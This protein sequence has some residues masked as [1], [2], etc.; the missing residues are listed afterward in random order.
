MQGTWHFVHDLISFADFCGVQWV[1]HTFL[2]LLTKVWN[3]PNH[4]PF[5]KQEAN[6]F[7]ATSRG[8]ID[9]AVNVAVAKEGMLARKKV[10]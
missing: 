10:P 9:T 5:M 3:T 2:I 1:L 4:H 7:G 8:L 6:L